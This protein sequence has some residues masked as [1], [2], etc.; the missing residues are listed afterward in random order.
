MPTY[1]NALLL[2]CFGVKD[3]ISETFSVGFYHILRISFCLFNLQGKRDGRSFQI[4]QKK[5]PQT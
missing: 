2:Y 5:R 1:L 3:V 4:R